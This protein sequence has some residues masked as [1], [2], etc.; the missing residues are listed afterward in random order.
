MLHFAVGELSGELLCHATF[1]TG[2]RSSWCQV[3]PL[4][5]PV[6][7]PYHALQ[8]QNKLTKTL[9]QHCAPTIGPVHTSALKAREKRNNIQHV[10]Y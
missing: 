1:S 6:F 4:V 2:T 7:G 9:P 5:T 10:M 3:T 8:L